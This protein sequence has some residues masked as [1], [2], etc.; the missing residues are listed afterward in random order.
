M[1]VFEVISSYSLL[2]I[3]ETVDVCFDYKNNGSQRVVAVEILWPMPVN[4]FT[5]YVC[6]YDIC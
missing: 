5:V 6:R 1:Y 2:W 4:V 3:I